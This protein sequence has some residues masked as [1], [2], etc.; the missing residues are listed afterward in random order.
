MT[1]IGSEGSGTAGRSE[2]TETSFEIAD[3][4]MDMVELAEVELGGKFPEQ[5]GKMSIKSS[6]RIVLSSL[7]VVEF[8]SISLWF[9]ETFIVG[10][11]K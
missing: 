1:D 9:L 10:V 3:G 6:S 5:D 7:L 8:N 4:S 2:T 11:T